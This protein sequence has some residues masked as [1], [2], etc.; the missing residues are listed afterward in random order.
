VIDAQNRRVGK[1][2]NDALVKGW[3]YQNQ[4]NPVAE[5]DG[6]NQVVS[7]FVYGSKPNVPDYMVQGGVTY[8]ILSDHLGSVGLVVN[9]STGAIAQRIDYDE[10]GNPSFVTGPA[11]FHL[12][13]FAGG[14]YDADTGLTRFGARDYD[15]QTGRWTT[16]DP[17]RFN[18]GTN[19][20]GY[21]FNDPINFID[22]NGELPVFVAI[23]LA[24]AALGG[25]FGFA[26]QVAAN[27]ANGCSLLSGTLGSTAA[28]ALAG[29]LAT[30]A[31]FAA[32]S[33]LGG[34]AA[35]A[36]AAGISGLAAVAAADLTGSNTAVTVG[37]ATGAAIGSAIVPGPGTAM[38]AVAGAT[39]SSTLGFTGSLLGGTF[40]GFGPISCGCPAQ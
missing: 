8:R 13:G 4:L 34:G 33:L 25:T 12:F 22:S 10:F 5:L 26:A 35:T 3:L 2:V 19:L 9:T 28:G 29:G 15:A 32:G 37:A 24:G 17:I 21:T 23:P 20:Y 31:G 11:D 7:R 40:G 30:G 27:A 16:K 6:Q 18:G 38:G 36:Y 14:L 1:K 39:L